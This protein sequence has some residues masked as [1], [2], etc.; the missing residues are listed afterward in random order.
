[1]ECCMAA[2][3]PQQ[4]QA[5]VALPHTTHW[6]HH[7]TAAALFRCWQAEPALPAGIAKTPLNVCTDLRT[8]FLSAASQQNRSQ[9]GMQVDAHLGVLR[10]CSSWWSSG[11]R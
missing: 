1:M 6:A 8:R 10:T 4:H 7:V 9:A 11:H 5:A 2:H 3:Y